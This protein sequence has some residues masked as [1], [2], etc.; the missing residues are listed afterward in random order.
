MGDWW[1][2]IKEPRKIPRPRIFGKKYGTP[3][4]REMEQDIEAVVEEDMKDHENK[5]KFLDQ[6]RSRADTKKP[7]PEKKDLPDEYYREGV[8]S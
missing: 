7:V 2:I 4:S 1:G 3:V 8:A 6:L 5:D